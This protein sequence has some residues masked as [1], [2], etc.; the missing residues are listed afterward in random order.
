MGAALVAF[1]GW[2]SGRGT[3]LQVIYA[4]S[5]ARTTFDLPAVE[6]RSP[7]GLHPTCSPKY[8]KI[9]TLPFVVLPAFPVH[10][11]AEEAC[12]E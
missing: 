5:R 4:P 7:G 12:A 6:H 9:G 1:W 11:Q 3:W 10:D 2:F 8:N